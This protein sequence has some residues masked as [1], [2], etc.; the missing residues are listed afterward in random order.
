[1]TDPETEIDQKITQ[2]I[3]KVAEQ[4]AQIDLALAQYIRDDIETIKAYAKQHGISNARLMLLILKGIERG[5]I[6]YGKIK[7]E[8]IAKLLK[9]AEKELRKYIR[10]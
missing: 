1:M 9:M 2:Q 6:Q 5:L 10:I 3:K 4:S 7:L 8:T